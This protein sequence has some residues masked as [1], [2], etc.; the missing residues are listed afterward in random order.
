MS[1]KTER[2]ARNAAMIKDYNDGAAVLDIVEAHN[3]STATLYRVLDRGGVPLRSQQ[4]GRMVRG[5]SEEGLD[6]ATRYA[7]GASLRKLARAHKTSVRRIRTYLDEYGVPMRGQRDHLR[8]DEERKELYAR[9][10]S[11]EVTI[12]AAAEEAG[13]SRQAMQQGCARR[14]IYME[15]PKDKQG[16]IRAAYIGGVAADMLAIAAEVTT[17]TAQR[18]LYWAEGEVV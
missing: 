13:I 6:I 2:A 16:V 4:A 8:P 9:I 14:G 17:A 7:K 11:G 1:T 12:A 5:L 18:W 10:D 15:V 3:I